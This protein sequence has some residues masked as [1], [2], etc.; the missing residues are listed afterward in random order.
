M[1][2]AELIERLQALPSYYPVFVRSPDTQF[3]EGAAECHLVIDH[4]D[5][6]NLHGNIGACVEIDAQQYV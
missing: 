3:P 4:V 5:V 1:I 2:V 6:N